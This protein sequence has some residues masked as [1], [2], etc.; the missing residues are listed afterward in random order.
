MKV[1][2]IMLAPAANFAATWIMTLML[3]L[4]LIAAGGYE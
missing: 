3:T 1:A 2:L 4:T